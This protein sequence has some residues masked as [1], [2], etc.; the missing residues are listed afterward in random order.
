M[1]A[2][3]WRT[4]DAWVTVPAGAGRPQPLRARLHVRHVPGPGLPVVLLHGLF[5]SGRQWRGSLGRLGGRADLWA[6]DLP[7]AGGSSLLRVPQALPD[8]ADALE[9]WA[10]ARGFGE[11]VVV[12]HSFGGMVAVDWAGRYPARVARLGLLAPA[13]APHVFP[14][15]RLA[16]HPLT[17]RLLVRLLGWPPVGRRV[18][19]HV[20][21]DV[22]RVPP[23]E[24]ADFAWSVSRC[25]VLLGLPGRFYNFPDAA[26]ALAAVRCPTWLGWGVRDRVLPVSDADFF[27][28]RLPVVADRRWPCGH[29]LPSELPEEVDRFILAI[30]GADR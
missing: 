9:A 23:E 2:P 3:P 7:G 25:R 22:T 27:A 29:G 11:V 30:A 26:A 6:P 18:F 21:D 12:G 8:Y 5:S 4:C 17:G 19:R 16:S 10:A 1:V 15:P 14:I 28:A 24:E 13:G 20:V